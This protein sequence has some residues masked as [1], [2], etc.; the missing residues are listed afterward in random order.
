[1]IDVT[2]YME[3]HPGGE[4]IL[5]E[6]AGKDVSADFNKPGLHSA[7]AAARMKAIAIGK[8]KAP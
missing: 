7:A 4:T 3:R 2:D 5:K 8:I 6:R 1:V